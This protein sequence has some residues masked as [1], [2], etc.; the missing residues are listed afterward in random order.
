MTLQAS[1]QSTTDRQD[2]RKRAFSQAFQ[3]MNQPRP[4]DQNAQPA[5][6]ILSHPLG[7]AGLHHQE[8]DQENETPLDLDSTAAFDEIPSTQVRHPPSMDLQYAN[9]ALHNYASLRY[10]LY[11]N[12][13]GPE[14]EYE[15]R[16]SQPR[17][18]SDRQPKFPA[19]HGSLPTPAIVRGQ[20]MFGPSPYVRPDLNP[21][22]SDAI[23]LYAQPVTE[24]SPMSDTSNTVGPLTPSALNFGDLT[25]NS[26]GY[27]LPSS[28]LR[29]GDQGNRATARVVLVSSLTR[30]V[31]CASQQQI[32]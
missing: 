3:R 14:I 13:P 11:G 6:R 12:G 31:R 27:S 2:Q 5:K 18:L 1:N 16:G 25:L 7:C 21:S 19:R 4:N 26:Q 22:L 10:E 23:D 29:H 15:P 8:F 20:S 24:L 32:H 28:P 9:P 17:L 30:Y